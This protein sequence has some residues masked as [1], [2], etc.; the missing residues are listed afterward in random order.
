MAPN[1]L[2]KDYTLGGFPT[3]QAKVRAFIQQ[4]SDILS[5]SVKG[6]VMDVP[7][8]DFTIDHIMWETN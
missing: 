1:V 5:Y 2:N 8:M 7:E 6:K 4:Y 3:F